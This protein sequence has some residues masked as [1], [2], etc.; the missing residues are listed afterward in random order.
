MPEASAAPKKRRLFREEFKQ[1][2]TIIFADLKIGDYIVHKTNGIGQFIGV[3]TIKAAGVTKDYIKIRYRDDDILYIPTNNL[4]NIRKY[5]GT[6]DKVPK[7][8]RLGTKEWENTKQKVK[9][10]LREIA[11]DLIELYS[12]RDN[13]RGFSFAKDTPWQKEFE[14]K[15]EFEE[16][17]DQLRAAHELKQDMEGI[18][19]MDRLLCGDVGYGKTEVAIRGAFKA[20]MDQKQ[21][22]Y[23]VPT[24]I[25]AQQ[26]Y[27]AFKDRMKEYPV[28][29]ELL[30]RFRSKKEQSEIVKRLKLGEVDIVIGTHRLLSEDVQFKDLGFLIID[31]EH[32]FGVKDK[33]KIKKL[34][35]NVDVLA[36]TATPIPRTLHMSI[37]GIRDMS[38]LYEP[39]QNRREVS[40]YV[41]EYD[42]EVVKEAITKEL[43]RKG[44]VF[45]LYNDVETISQKAH[46]LSKLVPEAK[47]A[48]AHGQMRGTELEDRM[49][50]FINKKI[51]VLVCTTILESGI[52]IP[53]ANTIIVENA[54]RLRIGAAISNKRK[55]WKVR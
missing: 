17:A 15:F 13:Q 54:D 25:L 48:V 49:M 11:R 53:N 7:I 30:N 26:Q 10:N 4:D 14:D 35:T 31:E 9:S 51:D 32:R 16:T 29:I 38:C 37:V 28:K 44:Q 5:I 40:T 46:D 50:D 23:L 19:P 39:P 20:V 33:E 55:S 36:M 1:S 12:I 43:E 2:E 34:K 52:D 27:E 6:G 3:N 42:R 8:S 18:K 22:A 24:T 45:Y 47:I 21:V 41:L